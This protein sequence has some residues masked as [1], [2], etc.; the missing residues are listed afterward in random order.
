VPTVVVFENG[1]KCLS[2]GHD[3]FALLRLPEMR[4]ER[5]LGWEV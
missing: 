2:A 1:R 4:R 3:P 5:A